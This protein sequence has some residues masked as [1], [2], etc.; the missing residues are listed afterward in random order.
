VKILHCR[1]AFVVTISTSIILL[2]G[3]AIGI[4]PGSYDVPPED[5]A[6]YEES[7]YS[8][9]YNVGTW[10]SSYDYDSGYD[11]WTMDTY[12]QYYSG[13]P[14]ADRS[15]GSSS[16]GGARSEGD[17]PAMKGRD[18]TS[19]YQSRAPGSERS[20]IRRRRTASS[21][22]SSSSVTRQKVKRDVKRE[23]TQ[24]SREKDSS[25]QTDLRKTRRES[26]R[27]GSEE[28]NKEKKKTSQD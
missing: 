18:S 8:N 27:S 13:S 25:T 22:P 15:S 5:D 17:R 2:A 10:T 9:Y 21:E 6:Y 3:C 1:I 16:T 23:T 28:N 24:T 12:Y 4:R 7:V 19:I 26:V 20:S 14:R 11:P